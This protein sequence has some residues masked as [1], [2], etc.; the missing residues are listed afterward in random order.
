MYKDFVPGSP[1]LNFSIR[2]ITE[3]HE[4]QKISS[5]MY[6]INFNKLV[7]DFQGLNQLDILYNDT[8]ESIFV[9][10]EHRTYNITN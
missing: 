4:P 5:H 7:K 2:K 9:N 1:S 6:Y 8:I 10:P 3:Y